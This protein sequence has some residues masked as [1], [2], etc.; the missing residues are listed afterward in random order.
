MPNL[1]HGT[2]PGPPPAA[3]R[4][5]IP[6]IPSLEALNAVLVLSDDKLFFISFSIG[7]NVREWR[8]AQLD[9]DTS[10]RLSPSCMLTGRYL[11][12][13]Y[14][15]HPSD[16]WYNAINQR[17]WLQYFS[18][19][20][21][22]HPAQASTTH[23]VKPSA[24]FRDFASRNTLVSARQFVHLLQKTFINGPFNLRLSI[25]ARPAIVLR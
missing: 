12:E 22:L 19:S 14:L 8:L 11:F 21:I 1:L 9:F 25:T 4:V 23:L 7:P 5:S 2:A 15:C 17:Y 16:F 20:D 13:F 10:V 6:V 24:S 18:E 3:P